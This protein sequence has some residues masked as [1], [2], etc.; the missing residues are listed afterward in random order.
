V[1]RK[2]TSRDP[3]AWA[4]ATHVAREEREKVAGEIGDRIAA[5]VREL[6]IEGDT[7]GGRARFAAAVGDIV[8][9]E[10][11]GDHEVLRSTL[12]GGIDALAAWVAALDFKPP[13]D[14]EPKPK[15]ADAAAV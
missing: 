11:R 5:Q 4:H 7:M 15:K 2:A 10:R 12:M 3:Q 13:A 1:A 14:I 6:L 8:T 9:A